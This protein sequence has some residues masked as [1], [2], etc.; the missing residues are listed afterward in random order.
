MIPDSNSA[1]LAPPVFIEDAPDWGQRYSFWSEWSTLIQSARN[2]AEQRIRQRQAPRLSLL[3][4]LSALSVSEYALR[5]A[6]GMDEVSAPV[7]VPI[8]HAYQTLASMTS[9]NVANFAVNLALREFRVG[10][11]AYFEQ[12]GLVSCFRKITVV[13]AVDLTLTASPSAY[14]GGTV[15]TFTAGA[16]VYPCIFG[17]P[18]DNAVVFEHNRP[19]D[20]GEVVYVDEL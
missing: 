16:R 15:P 7:V 8:W 18:D 19:H 2:G 9:A 12:T 3:Y 13:G 5:R 14:P 1:T 17:I 4:T 10:S 20:S 6:H 11:Y